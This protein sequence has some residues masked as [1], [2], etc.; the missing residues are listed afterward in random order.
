MNIQPLIDLGVQP[1]EG[2]T[3]TFLNNPRNGI[4]K[5]EVTMQEFKINYLYK[6]VSSEWHVKQYN[7]VGGNYVLVNDFTIGWTADNSIHVNSEGMED[8]NGGLTEWT[9]FSI[10]ATQAVVLPDY[11]ELYA[12]SLYNNGKFDRRKA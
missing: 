5:T 10:I 4:A 1:Y 12:Q 11:F 6:Y 3:F 2:Q 7:L 8:V 9:Y